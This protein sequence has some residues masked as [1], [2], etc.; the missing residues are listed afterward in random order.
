MLRIHVKTVLGSFTY[1]KL[2]PLNISRV[3]EQNGVSL[4]YIM[5]EI[6][7]SGWELSVSK[8]EVLT[9][10]RLKQTKKKQCS[11]CVRACESVRLSVHRQFLSL[12]LSLPPPPP[13]LSLAHLQKKKK[14]QKQT[15][16]RRCSFCVRACECVR[17]S[18]HMQF[19]S[20]SLS[21]LQEKSVQ[22]LLRACMRM[23]TI[24]RTHKIPVPLS[25]SLC[26]QIC[27]HIRLQK[28]VSYQCQVLFPLLENLV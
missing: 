28:A 11:F 2:S 1:A 4:L 23:C 17:L 10:A 26:A 5:L 12:S 20:L 7:H 25:L 15:D 18:V 8:S 16:P 3:S 24:V 22:K 27:V 9:R 13:P 19:L 6:H 21:H 14:Q